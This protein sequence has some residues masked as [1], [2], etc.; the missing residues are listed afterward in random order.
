M[1]NFEDI[2]GSHDRE[3]NGFS[4][5]ELFHS[6][7]LIELILIANIFDTFIIIMS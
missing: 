2:Q 7:F 4:P 5:C 6:L 3:N 1:F